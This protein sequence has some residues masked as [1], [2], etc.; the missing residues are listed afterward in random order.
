MRKQIFVGIVS[1]VLVACG[2]GVHN[3]DHDHD[4]EHDDHSHAAEANEGHSEGEPDGI[5]VLHNEMA[6][7]FGVK[8]DSIVVSPMTES[9]RC[10]AVIERAAGSEGVVSAPV[11][12]IVN[13]RANIGQRL[14]AGTVVAS[15]NASAVTGGDS[16]KAAKAVLDAAEAEVN[17]LKPLY[18]EKLVTAAEY[19][20]A[21]SALGQARAA[22]SPAAAAGQAVAP[23]G[24]TVTA[25]LAADG[26]YVEAGTPLA[27][28]AADS[29]L[30]L[31][32]R[33]S[34]DNYSRLRNVSDV[35]LLTA[36]GRSL[37]LSS[38]GGKSG[39][40]TASNGY[41]SISFTFNNDGTFAPGSTVEAWLL[42]SISEP[43]IAVPLTAVTEQQ[44]E[45][46]VYKEVL[47]EHYLKIPVRIGPSDGEH[48]RILSG[49]E[50]GDRIVT[51]GVITVRLAESSGAIPSGHNHSH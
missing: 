16:N 23:I 44:G 32:A 2:H 18:D 42:T 39:G 19:Q 33:T 7:R 30:T 15:I 48:V 27:S 41:A 20:A 24:G 36:D 21:V 1:C 49:V 35:R 4:H 6:E 29:H 22:Y 38:V 28:I 51:S 13:Y 25:L 34:A 8:V 12:G 47:P 5:V 26:A 10:S 40:V 11:A 14:G 50:A 17:R 45:H 31:S 43:A 37:L 46:F 3:H 9:I